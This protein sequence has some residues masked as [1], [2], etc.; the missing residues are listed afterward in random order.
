[1][2]SIAEVETLTNKPLTKWKNPPTIENLKQDLMDA[3]PSHDTQK[4]KI[5]GWLD[6]LNVRNAAQIKAPV[7]NS[8]IVPKLIRKQ[9]EWRYPAL[10]DPFLS[11][12]DIFNVRP[13]TWE[14]R[15][16]AQQNQLVLN[17]QFNNQ[18]DK[19]RFVDDYVR[20]AV[21]EGTVIVRTGWEFE[22][23]EYTDLFPVVEYRM[24][25]ELAPL[26]EQLAQM[27]AESPSQYE[28]DVP[29]E[30]KQAHEMAKEQGFPIEPVITGQQE[31]TRTRTLKNQPTVEICDYRNL[32]IDPTCMGD[33]K[34]ARFAL[35][36]FESSLS[37]LEKDGKYKNLKTINIE[38][39]SIL[40]TPDHVSSGD[41]TFNFT[42][43]PR[44][45]FVVYE[46]WG[47]WDIDGTGLVKPIVASWVGNTLIRMEENPFPDKQLP[48]V[49]VQYLPV[50]RSIYGEPDGALLEDN[51]KII[52]AVT[53]GMI[54]I[55][56]KS[57][58][59][60]TGVRKDALDT[61]NRRKFDKGQDYEFN[62]NVDPR[63]GIFMHT[64]PEIP[65]SAQFMLQLQNMEAESLTGVKSF[66]QGVS[67]QSLGDVAAGVR[68]ALDASSKRELAILRRLSN[69]IVQIGRKFISMNSEF[70][71][72]K[73]TIRITNDEF[74]VVRKD[75]LA[76]AFD[77]KLSI[78][79]AEED[80]N[81]AQELAFMLQTMGNNMDPEMSRMILSDIAKLRKM[82]DLA[83][84]IEDYQPQPDPMQ[85]QMQQLE[86]QLLQAK[87]A[88]EQAQ[89]MQYQS[90]AQLNTVKAGTEEVKQGQIKSDTDLKNLDFVEQESGV[91]QER[92]LQKAGEQ[93]RSQ[94]QLKLMD[95]ETQR[96]QH[97][98]D[99]LKQY[100]TTKK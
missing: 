1:M 25:P 70:L 86:M 55:M 84:K 75:D 44:K 56:G 42:D 49:V 91:K 51:Q 23:E 28:T 33:M 80:N 57:A 14:D 20:A 87:I 64:F 62:V 92:D 5:A 46:Y 89:T 40:G 61:T 9:A 30:L 4:T 11:T 48:F 74:V 37:E 22:E 100:M 97:K 16:A 65:N 79:T 58:N 21:D 78:S 99:L 19:I 27:Q 66:S 72:D 32:I 34:K 7:G 45:K 38:G 71:S 8:S 83:K 88:N 69:G 3:R 95:R 43:K 81:K 67:G 50:R 47:Y 85:Q 76:G 29:E 13:V 17:H 24:N 68:G 39:N 90:T 53:R 12:D 82:P 31:E 77:L 36:S 15:K 59:G 41:Q 96:E 60:Q 94:A 54:D 26:H 63:Q 93:A 18:I 35:Y 73:E 52:G 2:D 6:N 10:S 98:V